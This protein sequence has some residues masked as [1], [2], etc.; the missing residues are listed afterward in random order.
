MVLIS[1]D[2]SIQLID[3]CFVLLYRYSR[4]YTE[5]VSGIVR[6]GAANE[7]YLGH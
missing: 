3:F 5:C 7:P 6:L 2:Y 4:A 1:F